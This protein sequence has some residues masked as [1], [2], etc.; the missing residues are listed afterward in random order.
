[1]MNR[2]LPEA[3]TVVVGAGIA[4]LACAYALSRRSKAPD[5]IVLLD[6]R[7]PMSLTSAQSGENYRD[8]WPHPVMAQFARRSVERMRAIAEESPQPIRMTKNGYLLATRH[9]PESLADEWVS[10][11]EQPGDLRFHSRANTAYRRGGFSGLDVLSGAALDALDLRQIDP[12]IRSII[13]V[14]CGG[15]ID[16]QQLGQYMLEAFRGAGGTRVKNKVEELTGPSPFR[17]RLAD[18]KQIRCQTLVLAP[19]PFLNQ[20]VAQLEPPLPVSHVLQQKLAFADVHGVVPRGQP[21]LIDLDRQILGFDAEEQAALREDP[22]LAWLCD[23]LPGGV[24]C[25]PDG[26]GNWIKMGWAYN[27]TPSEPMAAPPLDDHFAEVVLRGASRL[28]PGLKVYTE[29]LPRQTSHYGGYYSMTTENWPLI[30]PLKTDGAFVVGALSGFG[31]MAACEAGALI[32]AWIHGDPLPQ[33]AA[34]L[35][36]SRYGN[37]DLMAQI[38][39]APRGIL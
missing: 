32:A 4:G 36:P 37:R 15:Q 1:M 34:P 22:A 16:S 9:D 21:F 18:G 14:R 25:R 38:Q 7:A 19:G 5:S 12:T 23:E 31:T 28:Q 39:S 30:G 2:N 17:L 24:H 8:W 26:S 20:L 10:G 13:H 11:L 29:R 27:Q 33:H 6:S 3:Q 35:A